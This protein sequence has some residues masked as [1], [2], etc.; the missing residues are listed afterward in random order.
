MSPAESTAAQVEG[1]TV[2]EVVRR[3]ADYLADRGV[4]HGRLDAEHLLA[5]VLGTSRLQLYLRFDR[6]L[7]PSEL[8]AC[9]SLL[10]RRGRREPLQYVL[11]SAH[12]RNLRLGVGP[13]VA[14]PRPETEYLLDA[15][16][17]VS[18]RDGQ[19]TGVGARPFGA[20]LDVGTGSGA[21]ALALCDEE[22]AGTVAATELSPV[23]LKAAQRNAAAAGH[24][25]VDFRLG[26]LLEPFA[27]Q[28]FDL[29]L[30]NPPYLT[31]AE[32]RTAAPEVREWEPQTAMVADDDGLSVVRA[33][34]PA[35]MQAL[36]PGGW[37]GVEVGRSQ[38]GAVAAMFRSAGAART[39]EQEDL[40]GLPRY[41]FAK[42][43][44]NDR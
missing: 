11:G 27:G 28:R 19:G 3:S 42:G 32:W 35:M 36:G 4:Q 8:A 17:Q 24:G 33:L 43:P 44:H 10:R 29:I 2:M 5:H 31:R 18:G 34:V 40:A 20:A 21:I 9:R 41:V 37:A 6:P 26:H 38:T 23:A 16:L 39:V 1:L 22:L 30:S 12:F 25:A 13:G 14:I 7:S 15:L